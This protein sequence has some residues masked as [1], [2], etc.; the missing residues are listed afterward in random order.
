[1]CTEYIDFLLCMF[2]PANCRRALLVFKRLST[3][4]EKMS[5]VPRRGLKKGMLIC[6]NQADYK[7][8]FG[9]RP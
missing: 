5:I 8:G 6:V 1:M 2:L 3:G 4:I 7:L 9:I